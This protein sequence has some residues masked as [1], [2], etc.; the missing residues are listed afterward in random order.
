M[1]PVRTQSHGKRHV[2]PYKIQI[3]FSICHAIVLIMIF[4]SGYGKEKE[5][6]VDEKAFR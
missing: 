4:L 1:A 5:E 6:D 3:I 2:M